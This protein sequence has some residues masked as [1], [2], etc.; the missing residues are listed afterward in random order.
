MKITDACVYPFPVGDSSIRRFAIEAR[1]YG[2]DSIV[3]ADT[4]AAEVCGITVIPG[5]FLA[6]IP[7]K[8]VQSRVKK[9]RG[10]GAVVAVQMGDNGFNRSVPGQTASISCGVSMLQTSVHSI[11]WQRRS[12]RTIPQPLT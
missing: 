5:I 2:Y 10:T 11:T 7:A 12:Q 4:P 3:A 6:G 9:S 1:S 8:D